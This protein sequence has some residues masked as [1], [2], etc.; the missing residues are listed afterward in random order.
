MQVDQAWWRVVLMV[1]DELVASDV[2]YC[3]IEDAALLAQGVDLPQLPPV[4][5][6]IQWDAFAAVHQRAVAQGAGPIR[7]AGRSAAFD[8]LREGVPVQLVCYRNTV[9]EADPQR[10][11]VEHAGHAV[12]VKSLLFYLRHWPVENPRIQ[13]ITRRLRTIQRELNRTNA[14][15]WNQQAYAAWE[16]RHGRPAELA[17]RI[18]AQP[19][20]R[21]AALQPWLGDVVGCKIINLLGSQ[22]I[23]AVALALLG[24]DVTVVDIADDNARYGLELA[25]AA[26]VT[27]R[28]IVADVLALPE[29]ELVAAYDI[30][31]LELGIL[32]YFVDLQ[33]LAL[34]VLRLLR[35]GGRLVLQ[36]FHPVSTK[37]ITSKGR[38]H[39]VTGNYFDQAL[40]EVDVAYTKHLEQGNGPGSARVWQRRWTLGEIVTAFAAVGLCVRELAEEPNTKLDD[41]GLPKTF[42][43]V[44]RKP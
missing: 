41:I 2:A 32:H 44:A 18:K 22:G 13:A 43:L 10:V 23:K 31:L 3:L 16:E 15:A 36:D 39:K 14:A 26:N 19:A 37:L 28:Y 1:T 34:V 30:V 25:R 27:I 21:L 17:A 12:W 9:V 20:A 40:H 29:A 11:L 4:T 6:A 8:L 7:D 35:T 24:A 33:P 42:T 5:I 38:K